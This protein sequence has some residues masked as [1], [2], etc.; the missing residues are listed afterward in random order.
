MWGE[1]VY[2]SP[3]MKTE[4]PWG[5]DHVVVLVH[6]LDAAIEKWRADGYTITPGG[7]HAGG[8]T[9]NAL[10]CFADDSYVEL[11]AFRDANKTN[12][13]WGRYRNFPGVVD[14]AVAVDELP[15][16]IRDIAQRGRLKYSD[17]QDGGRRRVDGVALQWRSSFPPEFAKGLPF[18]IEDVTPRDLRVP[19]GDNRVHA[20]GATGIVELNIVVPDVEAAEREFA[21]LFGG[22]VSADRSSRQFDAGHATLRIYQPTLD[23]DDCRL[24][25]ERGSGPTAFTVSLTD[26]VAV[27][28]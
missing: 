15:E 13:R 26:G 14:Y 8:Q 7:V 20:N 28:R 25:F 6:D 24:L 22:V 1:A 4:S 11:I 12:H 23:S 19:V 17:S 3:G 10:V 2:T 5:I 9:H 27:H 16:F 21:L 18:L